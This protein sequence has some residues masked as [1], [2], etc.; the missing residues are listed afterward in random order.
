MIF[1]PGPKERREIKDYDFKTSF[2]AIDNKKTPS[3]LHR[4]GTS[5]R[6]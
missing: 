1:S 6:L 5:V 2:T 3:R 4:E